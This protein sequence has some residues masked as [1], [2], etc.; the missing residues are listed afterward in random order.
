VYKTLIVMLAVAV[1]LAGSSLAQNKLDRTVEVTGPPLVTPNFDGCHADESLTVVNKYNGPIVVGLNTS[2]PIDTLLKDSSIAYGCTNGF[3]C[4]TVKVVTKSGAIITST[5][6]AGTYGTEI[7]TL[8]EWGLIIFSLLIL[9]LATVVVVRRRTAMTAAGAGS[10][11][12]TT[13]HGPLFIPQLYFKTLLVTLGMAAVV[14]V[15]AT[16][17]STSVPIRDFAGTIISAAIVAYMAHLWLHS[18]KKE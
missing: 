8:S 7:P 18:A 2:T 15:V 14:L 3:D 5:G 6:C 10:D 13:I 11:V 9:T 17:L 4:Y 12:S 1:L 16:I